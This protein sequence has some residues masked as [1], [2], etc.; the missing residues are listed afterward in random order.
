[1]LSNLSAFPKS[2]PLLDTEARRYQFDYMQ[3]KN[4]SPEYNVLE[5]EVPKTPY[6]DFAYILDKPSKKAEYAKLRYAVKYEVENPN[7]LHDEVLRRSVD[8]KTGEL[9]VY[10]LWSR[11]IVRGDT[12]QEYASRQLQL[13]ADFQNVL[14]RQTIPNFKC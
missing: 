2:P 14:R 11:D 5:R 9:K 12:E 7:G 13:L 1:V 3:S 4:S 6:S 10:E 8:E